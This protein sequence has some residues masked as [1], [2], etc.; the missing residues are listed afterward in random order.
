[1]HKNYFMNKDRQAVYKR[2]Q[3]E[4]RRGV[5]AI[6]FW[7]VILTGCVL[8]H[9]YIL[10]VPDYLWIMGGAYSLLGIIFLSNEVS[11][12]KWFLHHMDYWEAEKKC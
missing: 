2:L 12:N 4:Y 11:N 9:A 6:A 8:G 3:E 10:L 7:G 5:L 1:M